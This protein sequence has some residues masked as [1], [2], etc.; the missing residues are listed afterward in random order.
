MCGARC[1]PPPLLRLEVSGKIA[2]AAADR[3]RAEG[4]PHWRASDVCLASFDPPLTHAG[5][6]LAREGR[7]L[8]A[9]PRELITLVRGGAAAGR[10]RADDALARLGGEGA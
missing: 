6:A 9:E 4:D 3:V 7:A 5:G 8:A 2:L 1:P 10:E